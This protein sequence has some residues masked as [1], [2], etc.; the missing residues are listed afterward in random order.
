MCQHFRFNIS[1]TTLLPLQHQCDKTLRLQPWYIRHATIARAHGRVRQHQCGFTSFS[2]SV[3]SCVDSCTSAHVHGLMH[4]GSRSFSSNTLSF[5]LQFQCNFNLSISKRQPQRVLT[6]VSTSSLSC[7][8]AREG[9]SSR[10]LITSPQRLHHSTPA[11]VAGGRRLSGPF[12]L[13]HTRPQV[14]VTPVC[15]GV[16]IA[17]WFCL[18]FSASVCLYRPRAP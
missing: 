18:I 15:R 8:A 4:F 16:T 2:A 1:V 6:S 10:Q 3:S 12:S 11:Y 14:T 5:Q 7:C 17:V 9:I 13:S